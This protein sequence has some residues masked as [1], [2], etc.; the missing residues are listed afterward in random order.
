MMSPT[1]YAVPLFML[2]CGACASTS[3]P[4]PLTSLPTPPEFATSP[5]GANQPPPVAGDI[6]FTVAE[7]KAK[8]T[9]EDGT[10]STALQA[11]K[12]SGDVKT[13]HVHAAQ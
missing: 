4:Q 9:P 8:A 12:A 10:P 6:Q 13:K 2:L 11:D 1:T 7:P 5:A 3:T